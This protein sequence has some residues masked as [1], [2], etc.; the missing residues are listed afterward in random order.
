MEGQ[1]TT[2]GDSKR[3]RGRRPQEYL[4]LHTHGL[5]EGRAIG[6]EAPLVPTTGGG[7]SCSG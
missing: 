2:A 4:S 6:G 7:A 1:G 3:R 5:L